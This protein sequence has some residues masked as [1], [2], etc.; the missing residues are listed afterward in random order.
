MNG[1]AYCQPKLGSDVFEFM[2]DECNKNSMEMSQGS[3]R[4]WEIYQEYYVYLASKPECSK[5]LFIEL[6]EIQAGIPTLES[7]EFSVILSLMII[8]ISA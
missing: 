7:E 3:K 8:L 6:D 1:F 4:F 2:W 5:D